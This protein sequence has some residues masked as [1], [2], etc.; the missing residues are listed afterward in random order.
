MTAAIALGAVAVVFAADLS[1][2]YGWLPDAAPAL[3]P[4][5]EPVTSLSGPSEPTAETTPAPIPVPTSTPTPDLTQPEITLESGASV[6]FPVPPQRSVELI[7]IQQ[8]EATL[9]RYSATTADGT[10][11]SL[12]LI[13]YPIA[14]DVS[15]PA[16]NLLGSVSG[17]ANNVG[18]RVARQRPVRVQGAPAIAF[19]IKAKSVDLAGATSWTTVSCTPRTWPTRGPRPPGPARSS[20]P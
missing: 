12:G 18:G 14:V 19:L 10:T 17:A 13:E 9:V 6:A 4:D 20:A 8:L 3:T 5:P 11:Y 7:V 15:D 16:V 1:V 2:L